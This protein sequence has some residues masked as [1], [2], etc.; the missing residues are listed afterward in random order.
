VRA[1][2]QLDS[3]SH[4]EPIAIIGMAC[5]YPGDIASPED[6][7]EFVAAERCAVAGLPTDRGWDLTRL[8]HPDQTL[9]GRSSSRY[10]GGFVS[11]AM[12]FD[13]EFFGIS[14]R[15][16]VA[17]NPVQRLLLTTAWE[18]FE[19]ARII[20]DT[21]RG[22]DI[23]TFIG[24][25]SPEYGPLWHEAPVDVEGKLMGGTLHSAASGRLSHFFGLSGPC[26]TVDTGCSASLVG[27]HL[28]VQSLRSGECQWRLSVGCRSMRLLATSPNS[29]G[30]AL[31]R[32]MASAR[33]SPSQQ[34]ARRG[35]K[36]PEYCCW[37]G[38]LTRYATAIVCWQ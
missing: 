1:T 16:A 2:E 30:R 13:A 28:G 18:A 33:R 10:G 35:V 7:W 37:L 11:D 38:Y 22:Q 24:I 32:R 31:W 26:I 17:M 19:H 20:P 23:G 5:R 34:T 29:P 14:P 25:L 3:D 15:D 6:L 9:P 8:F 12:M 21:V 4:A 36:A 27:V